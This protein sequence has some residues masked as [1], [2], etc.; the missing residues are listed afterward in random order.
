ME[1]Y[2]DGLRMDIRE[3]C[4]KQCREGMKSCSIMKELKKM[5]TPGMWAK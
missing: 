1:K 5:H 2:R 4:D 3:E